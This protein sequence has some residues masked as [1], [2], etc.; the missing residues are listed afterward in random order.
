MLS[1][2]IITCAWNSEPYI[3]QCLRSVAS[4]TYPHIE[5]VFVDGGSTDGTLE[6]IRAVGG[7]SR[8]ATNVRGGISHAMNEG[9]RMAQGDVVAHLHGDDYYLADDVIAVV[10]DTMRRTGARWL[11]AR[12]ASD[13][14]GQI[15]L[16][17]WTMPHYSRQRLLGRNFIAHPATFVRRDLFAQ[18]GG[19]DTQLRYAMDYDLWLRISRL[20]EPVYLDRHLTAFRRHA[21]SASTANALV[22]FKEDHQVRR[23]YVAGSLSRSRHDLVHLWRRFRHFGVRGAK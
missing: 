5:Q 23:R 14:D 4:Q 3:A 19:F 11:F 22:A 17:S 12:I 2:S 8:W 15:V 1:F 18:A 16:P 9:V 13:I 7:T 6:R 21:G 20:A 10:A